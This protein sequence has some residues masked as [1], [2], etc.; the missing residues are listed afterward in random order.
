MKKILLLLLSFTTLFSENETAPVN[1][2]INYEGDFTDIDGDGMTD[3][4]ELKYGYNPSDSS[5][6]PQN[7]FL[8]ELDFIDSSSEVGSDENKIYFKF[9]NFNDEQTTQ[10]IDFIKRLIPIFLDVVGTPKETFV[11]T[12]EMQPEG[13]GSWATFDHGRLIKIDSDWNPRLFTH[14]MIHMWDGKYGFVYSDPRRAY[15]DKLS[16]FCEVAEGVAYKILQKFVEAYP[17]HSVSSIVANGGAWNNWAHNASGFDVQKHNPILQG[18]D[19]WSDDATTSDRYGTVAMAVLNFMSYDENFFKNTRNLHTDILLSDSSKILNRDDIVNLWESALPNV[20]GVSM[21]KYLNA[22]PSFDGTKLDQRF[23]PHMRFQN[24][25]GHETPRIYALYPV[26]G[27]TWWWG[28]NY[29]KIQSYNIDSFIKF[30]EFQNYCYVDTGFM[31]FNLQVKNVFNEKIKE[32]T[33]ETYTE[34][35]DIGDAKY[36]G[37]EYVRDEFLPIDF[38]QGL[39]TYNLEFTELVDKTE[40]ASEKFYFMGNKRFHQTENQHSFFIGIDSKFAETVTVEFKSH[41]FEAPVVNGCAIIRTNLLP[42]N[43][44]GVMKINVSSNLKTNQYERALVFSGDKNGNLHHQ[45]LIIDEDFDGVED[46]Y[47]AEVDI[48]HVNNMYEDYLNQFPT[49]RTSDDSINW[50]LSGFNESGDPETTYQLNNLVFKREGD[51]IIM[52][53]SNTDEYYFDCTM[54]VYYNDTRVKINFEYEFHTTEG[55]QVSFSLSQ[56]GLNGT[57]TLKVGRFSVWSWGDTRGLGI[58]DL[59]EVNLKLITDE[60]VVDDETTN[61]DDADEFVVDDE[62][63]N[64]D[65]ADEFVVDDETTNEDDADESVVDEIVSDWSNTT[66][67]GNGWKHTEW[68]GFFFESPISKEW[69]YHVT[70]GWLYIPGESFDSVWMYSEKFGWLWTKKDFFPY[71]YMRFNGWLYVE[72]T[73][74]YDFQEKQYVSF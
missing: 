15:N 13:Q 28:V 5:S 62:T 42:I 48:N 1:F 2:L 73:R 69:K 68:F 36:L 40:Y 64:E 46:A 56:N 66:D 6:F 23:Y 43:S 39:Y 11:T 16:G 3:V 52:S 45:F 74:Y 38:S 32:Y 51:K 34:Y 59:H 67:Y 29:D 35:D 49:H 20:N 26:E 19:L 30:T 27:Y 65:D 71:V 4:Y 14:E 10:Y 25:T 47:D 55:E 22:L 58:S 8:T 61:E 63:T 12:I 53:F 41:K 60:F 70:L 21:H 33:S 24:T 57:E 9:K 54:G 7:D 72:D 37:N 44:F 18:G 17:T 31:P 50:E